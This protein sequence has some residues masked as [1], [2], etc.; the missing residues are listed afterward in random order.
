[1]ER[2]GFNYPKSL[3]ESLKKTVEWIIKPENKEWLG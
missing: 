1:L 2:A 3:E